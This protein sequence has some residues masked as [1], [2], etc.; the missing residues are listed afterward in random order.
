MYEQYSFYSSFS[1]LFKAGSYWFGAGK[2]HGIS[3]TTVF[4]IDN[5][6]NTFLLISVGGIF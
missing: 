1:M 6:K 2:A 3:C 4:N 5:N